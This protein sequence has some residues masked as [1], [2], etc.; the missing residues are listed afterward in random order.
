MKRE[1]MQSAL[2]WFA[3]RLAKRRRDCDPNAAA[4]LR[5]EHEQRM[6]RRRAK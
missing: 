5:Q 2:G 1:R 3:F 6:A 4:K